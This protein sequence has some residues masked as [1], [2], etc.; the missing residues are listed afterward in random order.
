M[1]FSS[2]EKIYALSEQ[3]RI[4]IA[5]L[6]K[7]CNFPTCWGI[8]KAFI[9]LKNMTIRITNTGFSVI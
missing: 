7:L 4:S 3:I 1:L 2:H 6:W 5:E 8:I 9:N